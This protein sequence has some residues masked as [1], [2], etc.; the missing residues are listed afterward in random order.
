MRFL[1]LLEVVER[2]V[3]NAIEERSSGSRGRSWGQENDEIGKC[4]RLERFACD[5]ERSIR[6]SSERDFGNEIQG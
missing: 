5:D 4:D 1:V 3:K 2:K 6:G